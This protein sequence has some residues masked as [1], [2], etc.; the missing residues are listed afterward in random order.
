MRLS[1]EGAS[2]EKQGCKGLRAGPAYERE[3]R[4]GPAWRL[5]IFAGQSAEQGRQ[6][7]KSFENYIDRRVRASWRPRA[8]ESQERTGLRKDCLHSTAG[9]FAQ[10]VL[11]PFWF[12]FYSGWSLILLPAPG[13]SSLTA[14]VSL[15][16]ASRHRKPD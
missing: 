12:A 3:G 16:G 2:E 11:V 1:A 15:W 14:F 10:V 6:E 9:G 7:V 13:R 5:R 8:V 4:E